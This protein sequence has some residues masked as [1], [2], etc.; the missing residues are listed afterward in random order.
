MLSV[1]GLIIPVIALPSQLRTTRTSLPCA[2]FG[3]HVPIQDPLSGWPSCAAAGAPD[4]T[5]ARDRVRIT[6]S[7]RTWGPPFLV[8]DAVDGY[9]ERPIVRHPRRAFKGLRGFDTRTTARGARPQCQEPLVRR[10]W[11]TLALVAR[12]AAA[13]AGRVAAARNLDGFVPPAS[14]VGHTLKRHTIVPMRR[15]VRPL[16]SLAALMVAGCVVASL[17]PPDDLLEA[18]VPRAGAGDPGWNYQQRAT[19]DFD[20]DGTAETAVLIS[21]VLLDP[22]G[23]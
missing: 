11:L 14:D 2:S 8:R 18:R 20:G 17:D 1:P 3:P 6:V 12:R 9:Y 4:A 7:A 19:A 5:H 16:A 13:G 23:D 21:D 10:A 15:L 22:A